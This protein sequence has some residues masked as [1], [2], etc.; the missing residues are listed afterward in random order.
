MSDKCEC[1]DK[2][3]NTYPD[4]KDDIYPK[5]FY[6]TIDF[7]CIIFGTKPHQILRLKN[8]ATVSCL[9]LHIEILC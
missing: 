1:Q 7:G 3:L 6:T 5:E 2:F 9:G 8:T 4:L